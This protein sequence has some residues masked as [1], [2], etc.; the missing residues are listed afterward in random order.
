M[1]GGF[2]LHGG[3]IAPSS[4][5]YFL[6]PLKISPEAGA[7][8]GLANQKLSVVVINVI[9]DIANKPAAL[10]AIGHFSQ[11]VRKIE[12][13]PKMANERF[14]HSNRFLDSMVTNRV[15]LLLQSRL[16]SR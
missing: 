8:A 3:R 14:T 13:G 7:S 11:E 12:P 6:S 5:E 9:K 2:L 16:R 4:R 15:A 1:V 10:R